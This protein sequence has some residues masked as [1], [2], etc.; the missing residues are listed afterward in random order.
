LIIPLYN[1][2][3]Y[4]EKCLV[5]IKKVFKESE[6][7]HSIIIVDDKSS[8]GSLL[9]IQEMSKLDS[10][11][12]VVRHEENL[13]KG[14]ALKSGINLLETEFGAYIDA[15]DEIDPQALL[16]GIELLIADNSI[17]IA[18]GSKTHKSSKVNYPMNRVVLSKV[19]RQLIKLI[20]KLDVEDTQTG[21][22]V[23]KTGAIVP[24]SRQVK[25]NGFAFDLELLIYSNNAKLKVVPFE[26]KLDHN[27][28]SS[29]NLKSIIN[30]A[31]EIIQTYINT[32]KS[33]KEMFRN[34]TS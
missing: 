5:R 32:K 6:L 8:D 20:F 10:K 29:I 9:K 31:K 7:I 21:I 4:I 3:L 23:F 2:E 16:T 30:M 34:Y 19:F 28:D 17:S 22:K 14:A 18:Y 12:R 24:I 11:I 27:F 33:K 15:D 26:I 13:G 1:K 25:S